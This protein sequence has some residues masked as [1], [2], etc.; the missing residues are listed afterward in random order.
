MSCLA[1]RTRW[2]ISAPAAASGNQLRVRSPPLGALS[3]SPG[4]AAM[5]LAYLVQRLLHGAFVLVGVTSIVFALTFL[6]GDPASV[7]VPL[8]TSQAEI[9]AFRH[10]MGLDRPVPV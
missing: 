4:S 3:A 8:N 1:M 10:Q 6:T 7:L 2:A 5:M 9:D